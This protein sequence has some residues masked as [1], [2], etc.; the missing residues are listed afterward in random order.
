MLALALGC[1]AAPVVAW[2]ACPL[3]GA[4]PAAE[5]LLQVRLAGRSLPLDH[6]ALDR[7]PPAQL[8]QQQQ[9]RATAA[10]AP[11]SVRE[12]RWGGVRLRDVLL[13]AGFGAPGDRSVRGAIVEAIAS[14]GYRAVFSW[15]ELFNHAAGDHVLVVRS[16][17]GV[18][19][20][21]TAGPLALRALDDLRPGPRHVR[22][23]CALV[24]RD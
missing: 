9:V 17:D 13:H 5:T 22:N 4:S 7:L 14:D 24:V 10:A 18:P 19:L 2:A 12:T 23:L 11:A 15:G 6:A 1:S 8:V 16:V 20:D 3:D 21:A